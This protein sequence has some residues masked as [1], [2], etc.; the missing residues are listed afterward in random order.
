LTLAEALKESQT[1]L[2]YVDDWSWMIPF[3][4]AEDFQRK[5][6][7]RLGQV[8]TVLGKYGFKMDKAKTEVA[9]IFA[10]KDKGTAKDQGSMVET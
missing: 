2:S 7:E 8:S 3:H 5:V 6:K 4:G 9:W 10:R 1:E